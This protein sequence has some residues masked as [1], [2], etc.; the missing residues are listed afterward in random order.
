MQQ[1]AGVGKTFLFS[2]QLVLKILKYNN[3]NLGSFEFYWYTYICFILV[4]SLTLSTLIFSCFLHCVENFPKVVY[5]PQCFERA[6]E[7]YSNINSYVQG[8]K[9]WNCNIVSNLLFF[10][11]SCFW[12]AIEI[13]TLKTTHREPIWAK[14][15]K[16]SGKKRTQYNWNQRLKNF[17]T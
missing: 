5:N 4:K 17:S 1:V 16:N 13:K 6:R 7:K 11:T 15:V 8:E 12:K 14:D 10:Q 2:I 9:S 3:R